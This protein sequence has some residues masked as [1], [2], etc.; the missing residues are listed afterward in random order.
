MHAVAAAIGAMAYIQ[1]TEDPFPTFPV[2]DDTI[3]PS[4]SRKII[5]FSSPFLLF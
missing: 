2:C 3:E 5:M 4:E 1:A